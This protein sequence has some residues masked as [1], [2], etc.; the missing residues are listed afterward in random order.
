MCGFTKIS[1]VIILSLLSVVIFITFGCAPAAPV[2]PSETPQ[3]PAPTPAQAPPP[4]P[5]QTPATTSAPTPAPAPAPPPEIT[6][7]FPAT[8]YNNDKYGLSIKYPKEWVERPELM[9]NPYFVAIF[10]V[11]DSVPVVSLGLFDADAPVSKDW[12]IE[13]F[14]KGGYTGPKVLSDIKEETLAGGIKAYTYK[15]SYFTADGAELVA[16]QLSA[17]KDGKRFRVTVATVDA[18]VPYNEK[19]FSEIAHTLTFK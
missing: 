2:M 10:G 19:L 16:Y 1:L 5:D 15:V 7:S 18:F 12:I 17:D 6:T 13:S 14:K 4:I 9:T 8:T 11:S 3:K